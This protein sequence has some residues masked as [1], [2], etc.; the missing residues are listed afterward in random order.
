[1][2]EFP[3]LTSLSDAPFVFLSNG[4]TFQLDNTI[5]VWCEAGLT[6]R[7]VRG[8]K[9]RLLNSLYDEF[10]AAFQFPLYFGENFMA[11]D[12]FMTDLDW[13][14]ISKGLVLVITEPEQMLA[15]ENPVED[16][17]ALIELLVRAKEYWNISVN[18]GKGLQ[19]P[20]APT[21][22]SVVLG[23]TSDPDAV[24]LLW[25]VHGAGTGN[26]LL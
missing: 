3:Q 6:V 22:F 8:R 10:A 15:K 9:M 18:Y 4:S 25:E 23:E 12:D 14:D 11:L 21:P 17:P 1:V 13:M 16:L 24:R 20:A 2:D 7:K 19:Q 26:I 5:P